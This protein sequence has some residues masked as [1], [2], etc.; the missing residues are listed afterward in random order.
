[1]ARRDTRELILTASLRLFNELGEPS[2][3]TN[4]IA[5]ETDI[6]PGNLYY[7]FRSKQDIVLELFKRFVAELTPLLEVPEDPALEAEDLWFQLHLT[8]EL[9]GR[10]RFIYRNLADLMV[11]DPN[12]AR[13]CRALLHRERE[14]ASRIL[15]GLER[16]GALTIS[17]LERDLLL[18]SLMLNL[19]YWIPYAAQFAPDELGDGTAQTRAIAAVLSLVMPYLGSSERESFAALVESYLAPPE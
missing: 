4:H 8:F 18:D 3:S 19:T 15:D 11:H 13:A 14:A 10:F 7:H 6:S 17:R 12:L 9:K 5:D 16:R 2:V 1:M